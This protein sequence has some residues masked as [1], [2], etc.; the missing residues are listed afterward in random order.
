MELLIDAPRCGGVI[1]PTDV[2]GSGDVVICR[3]GVPNPLGA[4]DDPVKKTLSTKHTEWII[5]QL[6]YAQCAV[7]SA[8]YQHKSWGWFVIAGKVLDLMNMVRQTANIAEICHE[9]TTSLSSG[10]SVWS[11]VADVRSQMKISPP[12]VN[13]SV[14]TAPLNVAITHSSK[15]STQMCRL[16]RQSSSGQRNQPV[17]ERWSNHVQT[18]NESQ[19]KAITNLGEISLTRPSNT[20][21]ALSQQ[22]DG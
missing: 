10:R 16:V 8:R 15:S 22:T 7:K 19:E 2:W 3:S 1:E 20:L 6:A 17:S 18:S 4:P 21:S 13:I 11:K 14:R 5:V 9:L 12:E